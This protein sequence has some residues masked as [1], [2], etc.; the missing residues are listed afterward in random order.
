MDTAPKQ[1]SLEERK[2]D[3]ECRFRELELQLKRDES[4]AQLAAQKD[5]SPILVPVWVGVL[6]LLG[7]ILLATVQGF[8][9]GKLEREKAQSNLILK[10]IE[11]GN[12]QD[13]A[14][15]LRFLIRAGLLDDPSG[16]IVASLNEPGGVPTLPAATESVNEMLPHSIEVNGADN[17]ELNCQ[18]PSNPD[19]MM[20]VMIDGASLPDAKGSVRLPP[21]P[22]GDHALMWYILSTK[23][24]SAICEIIV[25]GE[26]RYR[27]REWRGRSSLFFH[28]K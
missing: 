21:L 23:P 5:R 11:T 17:V 19:A 26:V 25:N 15:N 7:G 12:I 4:K 22:P 16:K 2:F 24:L 20:R 6:G 10:A 3:A 14:T 8:F 13:S 1:A 27:K 18:D 28:S 9:T